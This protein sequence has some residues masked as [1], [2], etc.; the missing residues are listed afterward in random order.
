PY[1]ARDAAAWG[2]FVTRHRRLAGMLE[3]LDS[4]PAPD[5]AASSPGELIQLL[6]LAGKFRLLG[7][8]DMA[9]FLRALPI[10]IW[11]LLDDTFES[12]PL[13]AAVATGGIELH[14]QGP[15]SNGTGFVFLH[16]LT[17]ASPGVVRGRG[18]WG[19]G[20]AAFI[21]AAEA[22]VRG[23]GA[24]IR[25]GVRV[26]RLRV[27]DDR[28]AGV[29]LEGGEEISAR[30]VISTA[31]PAHTLLR[32]IDP[33]WLD[34]EFMLAVRNLRH[35]GCTA[36]VM[37][38]LETPPEMPGLSDPQALAGT[39][40]LSPSLAGMERAADAAKYGEVPATPHVEVTLASARVP[41]LAARGGHV[42]I[43]RVHYVPYRLKGG[44]TWDA[45]HA[46][47][48][49]DR[50]TQIVESCSPGFS[51]RVMHRQCWSP[52]E[53]ERRYGYTEGAASGGEL[54]LDQIL[55]MRPVPGWAGHTTP[56]SGLFLGGAGS[57]PGP[58]IL[59]G[60]GWL[61]ARRLLGDSRS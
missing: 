21:R 33:K 11:E 36:F 6:S 5:V 37:Y 4:A 40:S 35:R 13:K 19:A 46:E 26:E 51:G 12:E 7:R 29:V 50:V 52:A 22:A 1:S 39:L 28:V 53:L 20:A 34:P 61:A 23:A 57:H 10:S 56:I 3:A 9:E 58:G 8:R 30:R 27:E 31:D 16:Y 38:A 15:R 25:T 14:P 49:A 17:G 55:F 2:P 42:L 43:A 48:L 32:W 24:E 54:G 45:A 59:G 60:A 18:A 41:E 47:A 44:A